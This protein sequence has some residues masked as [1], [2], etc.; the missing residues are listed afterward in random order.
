MSAHFK[1]VEKVKFIARVE[2]VY[3]SKMTA[4]KH[5]FGESQEEYR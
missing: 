4:Q 5:K 3:Q 1:Q 2:T